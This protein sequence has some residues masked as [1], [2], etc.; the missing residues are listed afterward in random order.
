MI[1]SSQE[2]P[3]TI[4]LLGLVV[5]IFLSSLAIKNTAKDLLGLSWASPTYAWTL[6]TAHAL[7]PSFIK[8]IFSFMGI[9]RLV[10][11]VATAS[12]LQCCSYSAA[13]FYNTTTYRSTRFSPIVERSISSK[14]LV[15]YLLFITAGASVTACSSMFIIYVITRSEYVLQMK[16]GG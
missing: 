13:F 9:L 3:V 15:L 6:V 16:V 10:D 4:V 2:H 1:L 7:E 8:F 12:I 5:V 11:L 14:G